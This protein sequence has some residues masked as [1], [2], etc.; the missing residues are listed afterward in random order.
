MSLKFT[1]PENWKILCLKNAFENTGIQNSTAVCSYIKA[2]ACDP[3]PIDN[4]EHNLN[5]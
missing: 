5:I 2:D 4:I 3:I 1:K